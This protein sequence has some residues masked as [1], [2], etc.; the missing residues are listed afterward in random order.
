MKKFLMLMLAFVMLISAIPAQADKLVD[1]PVTFTIKLKFNDN[2]RDPANSTV[3]DWIAEETGI[4][5]ERE[6]LTSGEQASLMFA[7]REFPDFGSYGISKGRLQIAAEDGDLLDLLP[8]IEEY[9]PTWQKIFEENPMLLRASLIDGHLYSLP[10]QQQV[11]LPVRDK[12]VYQDTWLKELGL[13][14]P[15]TMDELTDVLLAVKN[16]AGTGSIPEDVIP[17]YICWENKVGGPFD[18]YGAYG[19]VTGV[20]DEFIAVDAQGKVNYPMIDPAMKAPLKWLQNAVKLGLIPI[21]C[22]TTT[23]SWSD[24]LTSVS[25]DPPICFM[26]TGASAQNPTYGSY[27][28]VPV[29]MEGTPAYI[30]HISNQGGN[31]LFAACVFK[32]ENTLAHTEAIGKFL[33]WAVANEDAV[34]NFYWGREGTTWK[35]TE[36]GKY[37]KLFTDANTDQV[38]ANYA[39]MG[40]NNRWFC[41]ISQDFAKN[42]LVEEVLPNRNS[43]IYEGNLPDWDPNY[44]GG[45]LDT[46]T[47]TMMNDLFSEIN[48]F[49]KLTF[50]TWITDAS[51][52]ID[53]A[54]DGYVAQ[55]E[56]IGVYDW[57]Q[58]KQQAYDMLFE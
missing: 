52:D 30:R 9:C 40:F 37:Q 24:Y 27:M 23:D 47:T 33:E 46:D 14:V 55:M 4:T 49:R 45:A 57:L 21:E 58:I 39:D 7:N 31:P 28:N 1:E 11:A 5:F 41:F 10:Y 53:A 50:A 12:W 2:I 26:Y 16:A 17:L 18:I 38:N 6:I 13:E 42:K 54:W 22:F 35:K 3:W 8:I 56:A 36:D 32:T 34:M 29:G 20:N 44:Y 19:I 15:T 43:A 51:A 25:A 48:A